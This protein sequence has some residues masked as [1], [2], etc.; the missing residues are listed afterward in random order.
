M[1]LVVSALGEV[2]ERFQR[3]LEVVY[4]QENLLSKTLYEM[5]LDLTY[6]AMVQ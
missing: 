5:E 2:A 1:I 3:T 4:L 6:R